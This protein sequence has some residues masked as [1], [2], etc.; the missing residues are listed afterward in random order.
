MIQENDL[1]DVWRTIQLNN[2]GYTYY[3]KGLKR[4][5][6][7]DYIMFM[8][9]ELLNQTND[10]VTCST[11]LT[12]HRIISMKLSDDDIPHGPG[13]WKCNNSLLKD[14]ECINRFHNLWRYWKTKKTHYNKS[15]GKLANVK[16]NF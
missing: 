7:I 5:S 10:V 15:G 16:E 1:I 6:R 8:S 14:S 13:R 3:H 4:S 9:S 2:P 11:G 12:D